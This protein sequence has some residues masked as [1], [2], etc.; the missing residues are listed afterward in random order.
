MSFKRND[1]S[2]EEVHDFWNQESCGTGTWNQELERV[3]K[4]SA[5]YYEI[6]R[7]TRYHGHDY[8]FDMG[9]FAGAKGKKMLEVGCGAGIDAS[10]FAAHGAHYHGIDLT[11]EA[12]ENARRLFALKGYEGSIAV[13][14]AEALSFPDH[15]FDFVY[16]FGVIHHTP[17]MEQAVSE[18]RRVLKP[19]GRCFIMVYHKW[20]LNYLWN[21]LLV[22]GVLKGQLRSR[23]V[24]QLIDANTDKAG[25]PVSRVLSAAE[26]R[27][28]FHAF[29][30]VETSVRYFRDWHI[31]IIKRIVSLDGNRWLGKRAG[32]HLVIEATR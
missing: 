30:E 2:V 13:D 24:K 1:H 28:L 32:W 21:I 7:R 17:D 29:R 15:H 3:E 25:C 16:S 9:L 18:I 14:N 10:E 11:E 23:S 8:L 20:S 26:A 19:G 31:P 5:E 6:L 22:H 12:V 4:H 27:R